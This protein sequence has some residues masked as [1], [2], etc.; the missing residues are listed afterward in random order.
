M[1]CLSLGVFHW[2]SPPPSG[3]GIGIRWDQS[4][5]RKP[6]SL[7]E[8]RARES[9]DRAGKW[10]THSIGIPASGSGALPCCCDPNTQEFCPFERGRVLAGAGGE[11]GWF[12]PL[13]RCCRV[14]RAWGVGGEL[15][16]AKHPHRGL[17]GN[18]HL[19]GATVEQL[20]GLLAMLRPALLKAVR[21][22]HLL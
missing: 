21:L 15:L 8:F 17:V 7:A 12:P 22:F 18:Q 2:S 19:V 13:G 14:Q 11:R 20:S 16:R 5:C 6:F 4:D 3:G 9:G 10:E 1:E